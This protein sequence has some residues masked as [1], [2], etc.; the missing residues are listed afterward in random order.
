MGKAE[1][2]A[3]VKLAARK[4]QVKDPVQFIEVVETE[5]LELCEGNFVRNRIKPSDFSALQK[6]WGS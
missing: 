4:Q 5:L 1:A 6:H 2:S 3:K